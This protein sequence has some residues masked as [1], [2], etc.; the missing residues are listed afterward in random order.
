MLEAV[1]AVHA[2][3]LVRWVW[4]GGR[5]VT[6]AWPSHDPLTIPPH[7]A[8]PQIHRDIKLDNFCRPHATQAAV[9][10]PAAVLIDF[11]GAVCA[12]DLSTCRPGGPFYG[13]PCCA[14][15]ALLR[16]EGPSPLDDVEALGYW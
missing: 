11:G 8:T 4:M 14:S 7:L 1:E 12:A 15:D 2:V 10:A 6:T 9:G 16:G 3:G 13:T 5:G